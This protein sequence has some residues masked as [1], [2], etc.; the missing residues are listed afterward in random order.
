MRFYLNPSNQP[1]NFYCM[2]GT[3]ERENM[4]L[5]ANL[6]ADALRR[7]GQEVRVGSTME[8]GVKESNAWPADVHV[9]MHSN[10]SKYGTARGARVFYGRAK[11]KAQ[12]VWAHLDAVIGG[13]HVPPSKAS[14]YEINNTNCDTI[15]IE[16]AF[17]DN[18]TDCKLLLENR[19]EIAEAICQGLCEACGIKYVA[20][21]ADPVA[22][23]GNVEQPSEWAKEAMQWA[24]DNGLIQG[25]SNGLRPHDFV[26]R[27]EL[28]LILYRLKA[29]L[30]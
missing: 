27:Q 3:N 26:T 10:A 7:C 12:I 5:I 20:P 22:L 30:H 19:E 11:D 25:D 9:P 29:M 17:H 21:A 23:A 2:G 6:T 4:T 13:D 18:P 8:G 15:Y 14:L 16:A 1:G 28:A 24:V